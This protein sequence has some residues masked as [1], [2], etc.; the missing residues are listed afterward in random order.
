MEALA[1]HRR[2][3][4]LW[5]I[6]IVITGVL[7]LVVF[8]GWTPVLA[9]DTHE[10]ILGLATLGTVT[11]QPTPT[12]DATVTAL[13]KEQLNQAVAQQQ[14]TWENWLWNFGATVLSTLAVAFAGGL[15]FLRYLR[16]QRIE[17]EKQREDRRVEQEKRD[18][19]QQRWLTDQKTER[20]KRAEERFQAVVEGLG[21]GREEAKVGAA[22]MLR[23]FLRSGYEQFYS[24]TFDLAVV[25]L[26]LRNS[27][28][29]AVE[30]LDPLSQALIT[31]F[32]ES[33]PLV[34]DKSKKENAQFRPQSLVAR[35]IQ[36][37]NAYLSGADL[38]QA[39][40][41]Q[42]FLRKAD[43]RGTD[44]RDANL[45]GADL[46]GAILHEANL[47][48]ADLSGVILNGAN[49]YKANLSGVSLD[50][51][52][53]NNAMLGEAKLHQATF[54]G[55]ILHGAIFDRA[56]LHEVNLSGAFFNDRTIFCGADLSQTNLYGIN[57]N[58]A[59]LRMADLRGAK[60]SV[61]AFD[62]ANLA[63]A[64]LNGITLEDVRSFRNTNLCGVTGLTK[65]QLKAC[66]AKGAII[67]ED[68]TTSTSQPIVA[69]SSSPQSNDVQASSVPC[70][71]ESTPPPNPDGSSAAS[72]Q[73]K[74]EP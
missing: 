59:D 50:E 66:K 5:K 41:P 51:A 33:F 27:N 2:E 3:R 29:N 67:D 60:V 24:Q 23:T 70:A 8:L 16:D 57:L 73:Q 52:K 38:K 68:L 31:V 44:L 72:S 7:L 12:E 28:P 47:S 42:A 43:L 13:N 63:G 6:G 20:E 62:G 48:G 22:I 54:S 15:G 71:Q 65:E 32:K 45:H 17:R 19:E 53:L 58:G 26:R 40:L 35:K 10:E 4:D 64:K 46:S 30:S 1:M 34:R 9:A 21:S 36:L 69:S 74:P 14:H 37:D 56:D 39:W 61:T 49:L 11:V 25:H 55:A 18:Q